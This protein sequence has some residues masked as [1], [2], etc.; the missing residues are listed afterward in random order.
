MKNSCGENPFLPRRKN[1]GHGYG[2]KSVERIAALYDGHMETYFE[3]EENVYHTIVV[4]K[5]T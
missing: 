2:L 1:K 5:N 4:L 3:D